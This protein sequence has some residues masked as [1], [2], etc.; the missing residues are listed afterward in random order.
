[1]KK[2]FFVTS[3][4]CTGAVAFTIL[5]IPVGVDAQL[6]MSIA[7]LGLMLIVRSFAQ[8][9]M[10]HQLFLAIGSVVAI[11]YLYWRVTSSLPDPSNPLSY[12]CGIV[13]LL[14]EGHCILILVIAM[15][16]N[17]DPLVRKAPRPQSDAE[18]PEVDVFI[19]SYNE[20][21]QILA[22]TIS[23]A[24]AMDY[25]REKLN[26]WL[27]DDGGTDQKCKDAIPAKAFAAQMRRLSLQRMCR[28]LGAH[29][30]TRERN[31]HAKAGNLNNGLACSSAEIVVVLDADHVPFKSFLQ[32]TIGH[33]AEDPKLFL[34]Q[35]PHVFLN[36]DPIEKNLCTF[37]HMPSENELFYSLTQRGLD[38]W[39]ASFFCGSAALLRRRALDEVGGFAGETITEDCETALELHS[40]GWNSLFVDKPLIAGLQP[41][42]FTSFVGQRARWCQGM[43]QIFLLKNPILKRGLSLTQRLCYLSS[44]TFWL[45]PL[46][47]LIFMMSPLLYIF[48][49]IR[50][51][52]SSLDEALAYTATYMAATLMMQ[53]HL[54]GRLRWPW[55]SE[56]YEF[57]LGVFLSRSLAS[58]IFNPR[59]PTFNVTAKGLTLDNEHLSE[60]AMPFF[61]IF[62]V[63]LVGDAYAAWRFFYE[64]G[65]SSLMLL[66]GAWNTLNVMIAGAA[67]GAIAERRQEDRHPR[68]P[69]DRRGWLEID[70]RN[71]DVAIVNVSA[72][73]CGIVPDAPLPAAFREGVTNCSL[74]IQ[75]TDA[76]MPEATLPVVVRR[77]PSQG[78]QV[79]GL[80]FDNVVTTDY[81]VLADLMYGDAGALSRFLHGRRKQKSI[82]S[83]FAQL[84]LWSIVEPFRAIRYAMLPDPTTVAKPAAK[85]DPVAQPIAVLRELA[86][87]ARHP[88]YG[89]AGQS[90]EHQGSVA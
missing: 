59:Q 74:R 11:R 47:R 63:L 10:V 78:D 81:W 42:T 6:L 70:S 83:G 49:D 87:A 53:S 28:E 45:F 52:V 71:F 40:R 86:H 51:F 2:A 54:Y 9:R 29:Y 46:P 7:L 55:M 38:K 35:T 44:M 66:V 61:F 8:N 68:L 17:L 16:V 84:G 85:T 36:P 58:V 32:E 88:G 62:G 67:L 50:I 26:V 69:V 79:Y 82:A 64:P 5:T 25:P 31:E 43:M 60:L 41:E 1:M 19:P 23:A 76:N 56:L 34:V 39:N 90:S 65:T 18:L 37:A 73:G 75:T 72:G 27:L 80:G 24:I 15:F 33:F 77:T 3:W 30:L 57:T 13:L 20:D 21:E 12:Y 4:L 89:A 48:F 14:A 22:M